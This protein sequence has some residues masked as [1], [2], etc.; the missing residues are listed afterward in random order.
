MS[1]IF[2][3]SKKLINDETI[4]PNCRWLLIYLL[5]NKDDFEINIKTICK[6]TEKFLGRD[7]V[8]RLFTE[9]IKAGYLTRI[10][11]HEGNLLSG[12]T[13]QLSNKALN[14]MNA[15]SQGQTQ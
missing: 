15:I 5:S 3:V 2:M 10:K 7:K 4:S 6:L 8:Y 1:Q 12:V 13:Y 11:N 9:A 14:A